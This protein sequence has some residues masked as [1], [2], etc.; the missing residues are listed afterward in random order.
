VRAGLDAIARAIVTNGTRDRRHQLAHDQLVDPADLPR[1]AA[2]GVIAN[3]Q[4]AWAWDDPVNQDA[5]HKL[6]RTRAR[7]LVPIRS[8]ADAGAR[9]VA[10][11]DWPAP[12]MNPLAA[13]QIAIT[14]RPLDGSA[15]SWHPAQRVNLMQMLRAYCT[16][17]AWALRLEQV[18]GSIAVGKSADLIVLE[19]DL[20]HVDPMALQSVRVLLTLLE[21]TPVFQDPVLEERP[22]K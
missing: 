20:R 9:V 13:M 16:D 12:T 22:G 18:S 2:L 10:S 3:M 1:F 11:S 8:L 17:A 15:P 5:E 19:R 21:G 14:R 7:M 4:P 6:G